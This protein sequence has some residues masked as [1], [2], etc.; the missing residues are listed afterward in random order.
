MQY[1]YSEECVRMN[2]KADMYFSI[3]Y[4][5]FINDL[6]RIDKL[7]T[8]DLICLKDFKIT[9]FRDYHIIIVFSAMTVEAFVND[10]LAVCLQDDFYYENFDK[11][12]VLQKVE[13]M[14]SIVWGE[15]LDKSQRLYSL[16]KKLIKQRN[17]FVHTKSKKVTE[18]LFHQNENLIPAVYYHD[19][20]D[21]E[22]ALITS[23][24]KDIIYYMKEFFSAINAIYLFCQ[25][26]DTHDKNRYAVGNIMDCMSKENSFY[27]EQ[28]VKDVINQMKEI[29]MKLKELK[30]IL[31]C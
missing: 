28:K 20:N 17:D 1:E 8:N 9:L 16:L 15:K 19:E 3:A 30:K 31:K 2:V 23:D 29:E 27:M 7:N 12:T 24:K 13:I 22:H 26:V 5:T 18:E 25:I 10:Y 6:I 4:R 21:Y 14:F 11:L